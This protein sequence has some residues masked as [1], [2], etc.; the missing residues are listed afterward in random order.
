MPFLYPSSIVPLA[1]FAPSFKLFRRSRANRH[2]RHMCL[3]RP[4]VECVVTVTYQRVV[5][6]ADSVQALLWE[7]YGCAT[8]YSQL[9]FLFLFPPLASRL[10]FLHSN[11]GFFLSLFFFFLCRCLRRRRHVVSKLASLICVRC[12]LRLRHRRGCRVVS[13]DGVSRR[14]H[15]SSPTVVSAGYSETLE[16]GHAALRQTREHVRSPFLAIGRIVGGCSLVVP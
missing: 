2:S 7:R 10:H 15:H 12:V 4:I 9:L 16:R 1:L 11:V 8:A 14:V 13:R 5:T 6:A 3:Q